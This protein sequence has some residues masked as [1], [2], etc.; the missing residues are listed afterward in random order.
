MV[1]SPDHVEDAHVPARTTLLI[2]DD[3]PTVCAALRAYMSRVAGWSEVIVAPDAGR[4]L[5][6]A[7]ERA[8]AAIVLDNR[9]PGGD[10]IEVLP[11]LRRTCPDATIVMHSADD[12][13]DLRDR[14]VEL[15]ADGLVPKGQPL[16]ELAALLAEKS[17]VTRS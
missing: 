14:A 5:L 2:V 1:P 10:G 6:L 7:A 16:G 9:M 3:N 8:P 13:T 12:T 11:D 4:G 17:P 15:G